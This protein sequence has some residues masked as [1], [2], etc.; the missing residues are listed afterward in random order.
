MFNGTFTALVTPFANN[1]IDFKSLDTLIEHQLSRGI[2]GFVV[3]GTTA[4]SPTLSQEEKLNLLDAVCKR[5][6]GRVPILFGS[7]SNCTEKTIQLSRVAEDF[8]IDGYLIVV[9]YYNKPPQEGLIKHFTQI[10]DATKHPIVMYN[11]P[12]RTITSLAPNTI[13]EL[14]K[15]PNIHGI[16][17]ADSNLKLFDEYKDLIA[18]D[19]SLLSGDDESC[20]D[21]CLRGGH[22][23]ISVCSHIAPQEMNQW[24]RRAI[25]NDPTVQQ[26]FETQWPWIRSLY[27]TSNPIPVKAALK[28]KGL[29]EFN[30]LRSP[31]CRLS[32]SMEE[33]LIACFKDFPGLLT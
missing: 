22:G 19:F 5:T 21:F 3:C 33:E 27:L 29:I 9:P 31:L 13:V 23:V 18:K 10:A 2:E 12:G 17:E 15:H 24:I 7:G 25:E 28:R 14:S 8:P 16:K 32:A 11:V 1:K 20:I 6:A 30:E 4:E 26:E